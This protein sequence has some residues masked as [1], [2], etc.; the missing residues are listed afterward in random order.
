V[1]WVS[2][3]HEKEKM[4]ELHCLKLLMELKALL[5]AIDC[6]LLSLLHVLMGY[7]SILDIETLTRTAQ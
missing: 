2:D 5:P 6:L 3:I 4:I 7:P 1:I